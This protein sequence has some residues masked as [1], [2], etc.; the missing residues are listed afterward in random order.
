MN[1]SKSFVE[2]LGQSS[3]DGDKIEIHLVYGKADD[4]TPNYTYLA[5]H[6]S[7]AREMNLSLMIKTTDLE[8]YGVILA[9]G[10]GEP[11]EETKSYIQSMLKET[12]L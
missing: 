4:G 11:S 5:I 7:Q 9:S 1:D 3:N 6:A 12:D 8:K 10:E 2:R